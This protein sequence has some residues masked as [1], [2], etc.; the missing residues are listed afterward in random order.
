MPYKKTIL[1]SPITATLP[2]LHRT[3][4]HGDF[5]RAHS[6]GEMITETEVRCVRMEKPGSNVSTIRLYGVQGFAGAPRQRVLKP[7]IREEAGREEPVATSTPAPA[8]VGE[9]VA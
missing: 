8:P 6:R 2:A 7:D 1:V 3:N 4:D 5:D 9:E